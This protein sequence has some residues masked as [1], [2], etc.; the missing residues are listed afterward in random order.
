MEAVNDVVEETMTATKGP[1]P[2][3]EATAERDS[4]RAEPRREHTNLD[5]R[6]GKIGISAVAAALRYSEISKNP[7]YAPVAIRVDWR[8]IEAAA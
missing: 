2:G 5:H 3:V 8:A 6:Y 4:S 1:R 7:A